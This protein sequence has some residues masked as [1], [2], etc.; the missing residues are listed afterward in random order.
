MN[1]SLAL[2]LVQEACIGAWLWQGRFKSRLGCQGAEYVGREAPPSI[3][4]VAQNGRKLPSSPLW[5][6]GQN[7][8]WSP[9]SQVPEGETAVCFPSWASPRPLTCPTALT[10]ELRRRAR[11]MQS[12]CRSPTEKFEPFSVTSACKPCGNFEICDI[13]E[14]ACEPQWDEF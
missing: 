5:I 11:A 4:R 9:E 12:S 3:G 13:E 10:L 7:P 1:L 14:Y 6:C 2:W 8:G